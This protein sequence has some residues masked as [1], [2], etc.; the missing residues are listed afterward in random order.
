MAYLGA[1]LG[2]GL[3]AACGKIPTSCPL[4]AS[5]A[6]GGCLCAACQQ[7][8]AAAKAHGKRCARCD[9]I[10]FS[11]DECPDC[12]ALS[13]AF[14]RVIAAFDYA[15]PGDVLIQQFKQTR[16][17]TARLL[18]DVLAATAAQIDLPPWWP[19]AVLVPIPSTRTALRRRGFNPAAELA[20][21]LSR[22]LP[23]RMR[24]DWLL[25]HPAAH[26]QPP[27][28]Q[29]SREARL[30]MQQGAYVCPLALSNAH[31]VLVDDVMTTGATLHSAANVLLDAGAATVWGLV[32]ARAPAIER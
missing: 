9:L 20:R 19:Q 2:A 18:A 26:R 10:G 11:A 29:L 28:K 27:Q 14:E 6:R 22:R 1:L 30:W 4:C 16:F 13:P 15:A 7:E 23:L 5:S 8:F 31:V 12:L 17:Q 3:A 24:M 32:A 21:Q 25:R